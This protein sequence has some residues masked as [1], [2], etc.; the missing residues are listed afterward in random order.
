MT[1]GEPEFLPGFRRQKPEEAVVLD[2]NLPESLGG[3]VVA[4]LEPDGRFKLKF[5]K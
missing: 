1:P 2:A 5:R 3:A 4:Q